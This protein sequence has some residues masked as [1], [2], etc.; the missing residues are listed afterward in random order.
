M[1]HKMV[2]IPCLSVMLV[3]VAASQGSGAELTTLQIEPPASMDLLAGQQLKLTASGIYA[4]G[5]RVDLSSKVQWSASP[6]GSVNITS[7]G[8]VSMAGSQRGPGMGGGSGGP[9]G[10]GGPGQRGQ[11][12][13][14]PAQGNSQSAR[15][16]NNNG[17]SRNNGPRSR[18]ANRQGNRAMNRPGGF[19]GAGG[20][21]GGPG[22]GGPGMGGPGGPGGGRSMSASTVDIVASLEGYASKA[23]TLTLKATEGPAIYTQQGQSVIKK[24]LVITT[25]QA[26]TSAIK[27]TDKGELVL[28]GAQIETRG[29]TNHMENSSFYGLNAGILALSK[30]R[31]KVADSNI[32]TT[33]TGA[34]GAFAVGSGSVVELERVMIDCKAS[35]AHGVDAT[36]T[37]TV[38]CTDVD[39]KTAGNGASAAI[40]TDRGSGTIRF[41]RGSAF[42]SG[43]RSPGIY[44]TGD[45]TVTDA[46]IESTASEA[47]VIEGKNS[48][49]LNNTRLSCLAQCGA[50][51]YQ[52]FSGDAGVGTSVLTMN[53]GQLHAA[54]GPM[55]KI[56]NT[57]AQIHLRNQA[58]LTA[59]SGVLVSA[60]ADRW[61]RSGSN[62]GHL[63]LQADH[64]DLSGNIVCDSV[65]SVKVTL[66][67]QSHWQG[68]VLR[69]ED[70]DVRIDLDRD[71][72][73][74]VTAD[75]TIT[76]LTDADAT[77]ANLHD[78]GHTIVYD[79]QKS[80]TLAG[81]TYS[82]SG[83]GKL[84]PHP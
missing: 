28:T 16:W 82:L 71:S 83:G 9:G 4:D 65:S 54:V 77:L 46:V 8:I 29:N 26:C 15:P 53:G 47:I 42:T 34:N 23:L 80:P 39:I 10:P 63:D 84:V 19:G 78:N 11:F 61:G 35:G 37:G 6:M 74:E 51:L 31:M 2:S 43:T 24:E 59:D 38:I 18:R 25:D 66:K 36:L 60:A 68:A 44:S 5:R 48:V 72:V 69:E 52:S 17:Q 64:E 67:N 21:M 30:G 33:G 75:S 76:S 20:G 55:F 79:A 45:I 73:W 7:D 62:G 56:T 58:A 50:M 57:R 14:P 1:S 70:G 27:V 41:T 32:I 40:S 22:M 81:K 13:G 49:T 12:G 3:L